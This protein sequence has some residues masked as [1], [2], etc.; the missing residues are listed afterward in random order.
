[1]A[2]N[3]ILDNTAAGAAP[4]PAAATAAT[5][6][7]SSWPAERMIRRIGPAM[8]P[9]LHTALQL[10]EQSE[11]HIEVGLRS[12]AASQKWKQVYDTF[13]HPLNGPGRNFSMPSTNPS[14]RFKLS[15]LSAMEEFSQRYCDE[16]NAG[17]CR[18][19]C[20]P[21]RTT[22]RLS[23]ATRNLRWI[24]QRRSVCRPR[25]NARRDLLGRSAP[26]VSSPLDMELSIQ[27]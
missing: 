26:W 2:T 16:I 21:S 5:G 27:R 15:I 7:P 3:N 6:I 20:S 24:K 23:V 17:G 14:R 11:A 10:V 12:A 22:S 13:F 19:S 25:S 18:P 4:A 1:M 9:F 8:E